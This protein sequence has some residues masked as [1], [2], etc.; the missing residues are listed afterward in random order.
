VLE[1]ENPGCVAHI[2]RTALR[3]GGHLGGSGQI[4]FLFFLFL[5]LLVILISYSAFW[6]LVC[7]AVTQLATPPTLVIGKRPPDFKD[8]A[9][10]LLGAKSMDLF[11]VQPPLDVIHF[12]VNRYDQFILLI[13]WCQFLLFSFLFQEQSAK[14]RFYAQTIQTLFYYS[15]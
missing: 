6:F 5:F 10:R 3:P 11:Y 4:R 9:T 13:V 1:A 15:T 14:I 2:K 7:Y 8:A 12:Q